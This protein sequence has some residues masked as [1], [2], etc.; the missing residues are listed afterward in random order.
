[1]TQAAIPARP[2]RVHVDRDAPAVYTTSELAKRWKVS[3]D[4]VIALIRS[5]ALIGFSVSKPGS[6]KPRFRVSAAEVEAFEMRMRVTKPP[7][8]EHRRRVSNSYPRIV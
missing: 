1:M 3:I 4:Q 2:T 6:L 7:R 8:I 5:E